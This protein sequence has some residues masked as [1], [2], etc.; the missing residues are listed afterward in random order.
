MIL[1]AKPDH[2]DHWGR[3]EGPDLS[4][5]IMLGVSNWSVI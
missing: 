5:W 4:G 1:L 3:G 2:S